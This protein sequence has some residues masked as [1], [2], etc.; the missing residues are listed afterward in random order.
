[1]ENK[2]ENLRIKKNTLNILRRVS[3]EQRVLVLKPVPIPICLKGII[4]AVRCSCW[5][6]RAAASQPP[7]AEILRSSPAE[8]GQRSPSNSETRASERARASVTVTSCPDLHLHLT[9]T[10]TSTSTSTLSTALTSTATSS[11]F[12]SRDTV[13]KVELQSVDKV[14]TV[15]NHVVPHLL[16]TLLPKHLTIVMVKMEVNVHLYYNS[17]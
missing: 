2:G 5:R 17:G 9:P 10:L 3:S 1:M 16:K 14:C 7:S 6:V 15:F 12:L 11:T 8:A 4:C 13:T